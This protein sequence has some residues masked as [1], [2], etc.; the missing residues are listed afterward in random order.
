[1]EER[2]SGISS[3]FGKL[4]DEL[5]ELFQTSNL[6][7]ENSAKQRAANEAL[8]TDMGLEMRRM[9]VETMVKSSNR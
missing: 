3:D 2:A 7:R 9:P 6:E 5:I 4:L 1:M 8:N